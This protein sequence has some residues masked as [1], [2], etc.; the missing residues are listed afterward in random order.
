MK[1]SHL[2]IGG[3]AATIIAY[4]VLSR[5]TSTKQPILGQLT[6]PIATAQL[7]PSLFNISAPLAIATPIAPNP[8]A[9]T[10]TSPLRVQLASATLATATMRV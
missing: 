2:I 6:A 1:T 3:A 5:R 4:V 9:P 8:T 10:P 7:A